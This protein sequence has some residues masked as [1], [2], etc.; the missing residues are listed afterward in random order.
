MYAHMGETTFGSPCG[1]QLK[2]MM[3]ILIQNEGKN[4]NLPNKCRNAHKKRITNLFYLFNI[5]LDEPTIN[6]FPGRP[7]ENKKRPYAIQYVERQ[8]CCCRLAK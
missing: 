3:Q 1:M 2:K 4:I 7:I 8:L 6:S 5:R